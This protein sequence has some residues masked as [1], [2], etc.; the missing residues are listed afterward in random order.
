MK[1]QIGSIKYRGK[2]SSSI[3]IYDD[4]KSDEFSN[5]CLEL[6]KRILKDSKRSNDE[7]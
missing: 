3:P 5:A 7:E 2:D 4:L 6:L 1:L